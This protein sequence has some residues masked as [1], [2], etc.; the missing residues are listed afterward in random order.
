[1]VLVRDVIGFVECLFSIDVF[2]GKF[3]LILY[4]IRYCGCV[5]VNVEFRS[6]SK[7][8]IFVEF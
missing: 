5:F 8:L 2:L 4:K 3:I 6:G 7:K 1:M